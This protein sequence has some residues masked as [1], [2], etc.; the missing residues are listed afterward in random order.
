MNPVELL[1]SIQEVLLDFK[2]KNYKCYEFEPR[3]GEMW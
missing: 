2:K 1:V 3:S